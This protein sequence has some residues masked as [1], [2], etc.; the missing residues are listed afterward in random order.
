MF[1]IPFVFPDIYIGNIPMLKIYTCFTV[2]CI[3]F[4]QLSKDHQINDMSICQ[5]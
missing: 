4:C 5:Y 1:H 3:Q 2:I